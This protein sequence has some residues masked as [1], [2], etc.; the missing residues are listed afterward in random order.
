MLGSPADPQ[1]LMVRRVAALGIGVVLVLLLVFGIN[2]CLKGRKQQSLKDYDRDVS[3]IV[4]DANL[5]AKD[6]F[7]KLAGSGSASTDLQSDINQL[8]FH[9]QGLTKQA[10]SLNVPGDMAPAQRNLLLALSLIQ[11]S[12]GKVAEKLPA[13]LSTDSST[14][15][16][17]V[18]G[19]AGEMQ[20]FTAADVIY[21]RRTAALIKQV[22]DDNNIGGQVIQSSSFQQN[23]GWLTPSTVAKRINSQAGISAGNAG[24]VEPAK[25]THGH[26][27][28]SVAVGSQTLRP[29]ASNV[30]TVGSSVTFSVVIANQGE[31]A[32]SDVT[33]RIRIRGSH[34]SPITAQTVVDQTQP[35]TQQ[36]VLVKLTKP[37]PFEDGLTITAQV[38]PVLGETQT[39]NNTQTFPTLLHRG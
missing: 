22:L 30:L 37:P 4:Q 1:Q 36:T 15:V 31:N 25:G 27:I 20:A 6:F 28:I 17:A 2:G 11:E 24:T 26:G 18:E 29:D 32:E 19:I 10:E 7:A 38:L 23:L 8:R 9:A 35:K 33:V 39:A 13:A 34:G 21:N 14:A 16:P 12:M 3:S 5:N